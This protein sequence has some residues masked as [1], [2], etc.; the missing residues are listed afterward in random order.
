MAYS[1]AWRSKQFYVDPGE[2]LHNVSAIEHDAGPHTEENDYPINAGVYTAP[3]MQPVADNLGE[4]PDLYWLPDTAGIVLN[5][6]PQSH[7]PVK[8]GDV[9]KLGVNGE[10]NSGSDFGATHAWD[11]Y[12]AN[13]PGDK[14][15][16][17][18]W[19]DPSP[20][21]LVDGS[22]TPYARGLGAAAINQPEGYRGG[23]NR[24]TW[25]DRKNGVEFDRK[26]ETRIVTA[27]I[28][29]AATDT[30]PVPGR[31]GTPFRNLA[32][33]ITRPNTPML[34]REPPNLSESYIDGGEEEYDA[35]SEYDEWLVD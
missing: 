29:A 10:H 11:G 22:S 17:E 4:Y 2:R 5:E 15:N 24:N 27:N 21:N 30:P 8:Y 33:A 6:T 26:H 20:T 14:Y 18:A 31:Y 23:N 34:R 7:D 28:A 32:R 13:W 35:G 16:G 3:P 25:V 9:A 12:R 1:G 19:V